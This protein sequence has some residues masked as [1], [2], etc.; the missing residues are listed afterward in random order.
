M[1]VSLLFGRGPGYVNTSLFGL[2]PGFAFRY[3]L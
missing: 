3:E 1:A 2:I